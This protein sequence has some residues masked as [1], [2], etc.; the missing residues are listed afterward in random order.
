MNTS[1]KPM[2][3]CEEHARKLLRVEEA[4]SLFL[5]SA[6]LI[7]QHESIPT[8]K[9]LGR[10]L[11]EDIF[12]PFDMPTVDNSA[13]DGYA[14]HLNDL[15]SSHERRLKIAQTIPAGAAVQPF[16]QGSCARIFTGAPLPT[17]A[18]TVI[19]QEACNIED[20]WVIFPGQIEEGANIRRQGEE[21][22]GG[23]K[24]LSKGQKI[25]A[26]ELGMIATLGLARVTVT[27][28]LK[29]AI[30]STGDELTPLG[31]LRAS[32]H[33]YDSNRYV[34]NALLQTQ[35]HEVIDLGV[36]PDHLQAICDTLREAAK[37]DLIITSG[38]VS[39]GDED[40]VKAAVAQLGTID[41]WRIA[42][43]PGKPLAYGTVKE[44][45]FFGLPGN[46][47]A[48]FI[49]FCLFVRPYLQSMQGIHHH[50]PLSITLPAGFSHK[51]GRRREY[52][53][54]NIEQG[55]IVPLP[56]QG[57]AMMS[58]LTQSEGLVVIPEEQAVSE[59]DSLEFIPY[60]AYFS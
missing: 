12:S 21:V 31:E 57:S 43:K 9:A 2:D 15:K 24:L 38:G 17:G 19:P 25:R 20:G 34:L 11:T 60:S 42:I 1:D 28:P 13:M 14:I 10:V 59:S 6:P 29:V 58:S 16:K 3:I 56:Q 5:N 36:V 41:S 30:F 44:T 4:L 35:G 55:R 32:G 23:D 49:T 33:I 47:V 8:Q 50:T 22:S 54:A 37:A 52:L 51:P 27:R 53:R 7:T 18:D 46:P 26:Q 39:V 45:P 40:H 48:T